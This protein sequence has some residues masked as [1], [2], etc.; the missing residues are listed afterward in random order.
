MINV[1]SIRFQ[2]VYY[3]VF[4]EASMNSYSIR[5]YYNII[6]WQCI[7]N[8]IYIA[9]FYL[10]WKVF[11]VVLGIDFIWR[12]VVEKYILIHYSGYNQFNFNGNW[13]EVWNNGMVIIYLT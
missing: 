1:L 6:L 4:I 12:K 10:H 7:V 11:L 13:Y 3:W 9:E 8:W 5:V 2:F